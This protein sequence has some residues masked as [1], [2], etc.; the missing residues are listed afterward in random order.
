METI[1]RLFS[2][3]L[4]LCC[5]DSYYDRDYDY[6]SAR[7]AAFDFDLFCLILKLCLIG[8]TIYFLYL[9]VKN[10]EANKHVAPMA[11]AR[12]LPVIHAE[13]QLKSSGVA[14]AKAATSSAHSTHHAA[15]H[16]VVQES[17]IEGQTNKEHLVHH[18]A[19]HHAAVEHSNSTAKHHSNTDATH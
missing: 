12:P 4:Y 18:G 8:G 15:H 5:R 16:H 17:K 1:F 3:I 9:L 10:Y 6:Y 13:N 19:H 7:R 11:I 14:H 2:G